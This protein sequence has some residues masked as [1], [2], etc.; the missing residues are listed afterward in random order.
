M[1]SVRDLVIKTCRAA[2]LALLLLLLPRALRAQGAAEDLSVSIVTFGPGDHAFSKFGH[3]AIVIGSGPNARVY[4]FGTFRFDSPWL[5]VDF[6]Q[7]RLQYWLSVGGLGPTIA[8]YE[9]DNR[10]IDLQRLRLTRQQALQLRRELER[11]ALPANRYYK[12]DYYYDNCST[13]VRDAIDR[14][15]GGAL[16]ESSAGPGSMSYREHTLRLVAGDWLLWMGLHW[17]L[18]GRA[19]GPI[20]RWQES[21]LPEKLAHALDNATNPALPGAP[22]LV[23]H[24]Q[25]V[26]TAARDAERSRPPN[27]NLAGLLTGT[28]VGAGLA[29]CAR[30]SATRRLAR[31]ALGLSLSLVGLV[32]GLL[33]TALAVLWCTDHE[34]AHA[35]QNLL[36]AAPF[37]LLLTPAGAAVALG[38]AWGWRW[39]YPICIGAAALVVLALMIKAL[40]GVVQDNWFFVALMAPIWA[41]ALLGIRWR[42]HHDRSRSG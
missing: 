7:G 16:R 17:G 14:T 3:D 37:V 15:L 33:G 35:N 42:V 6:L 31:V 21:F 2:L 38:R 20:T 34:I 4:N 28:L 18:A 22:P 8:S 12:Y 39:S 26:F 24:E 13:R 23:A 30:A 11:T 27:R 1:R 41:G 5:L 10:S 19:D 25:R 40:P 32:A 29:G 9:D 36:L